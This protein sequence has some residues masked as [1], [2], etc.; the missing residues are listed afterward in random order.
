M[1]TRTLAAGTALAATLQL[2]TVNADADK[3]R[4]ESDSTVVKQ[5]PGYPNNASCLVKVTM[6]TDNDGGIA[7]F[8]FSLLQT[9]PVATENLIPADAN[10]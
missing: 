8:G 4:L 10:A 1:N 2:T 5:S 9:I 6:L 7:T 3:V